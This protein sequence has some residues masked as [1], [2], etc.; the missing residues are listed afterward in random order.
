MGDHRLTPPDIA[1]GAPFAIA[2]KGAISQRGLALSRIQAR[3]ADAGH[4]VGVATLSTW[5]SGSRQPRPDSR[6]VVAA[7]EQVLDVPEGWLTV[8]L[9]PGAE[10]IPIGRAMDSGPVMAR[11]LSEVRRDAHGK[12]QILGVVEELFIGKD[13]SLQSKRVIQTVQ[14]IEPTDRHIVVHGGDEGCDVELIH[15]RS[16]GGARPGRMA[17]DPEAVLLLGEMLFDRM[18]QPGDTAVLRFEVTD[19]NTVEATEYVRFNDRPGAHHLLVV[20]FDRESLPVRV[21]EFRRKHSSAPDSYRRE[22]MLSPDGV[23]HVLTPE[24]EVG[25][26]GID[27]EWT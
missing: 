21:S 9:T 5:Q 26:V 3:L 24:S 16:I 17:R 13:R 8:R 4:H 7:L 20:Q 27:W 2:L 25:V 11:L 15:L 10:R 12:L 14:A 18:L 19:D 22:L 1:P 23:V 6:D